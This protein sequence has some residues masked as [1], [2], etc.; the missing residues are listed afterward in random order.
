[1]ELVRQIE[2]LLF[3]ADEPISAIELA[4]FLEVDEAD[5]VTV[6]RVSGPGVPE[7]HEK[8]HGSPRAGGGKVEAAGAG[9]KRPHHQNEKR[10]PKAPPISC[11][12]HWGLFPGALA[13]AQLVVTFAAIV[14]NARLQQTT[15]QRTEARSTT[16]W[17]R[18]SAALGAAILALLLLLTA[19]PMAALVERSFHG[20][21]ARPEHQAGHAR[22]AS[23]QLV[24]RA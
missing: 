4:Q 1:M 8:S 12:A 3:V 9:G 22:A 20:E 6:R 10:D 13:L 23:S 14:I 11:K 2:A 19:A 5:V 17:D 15:P 21:D 16:P 7:A 18:K 24:S